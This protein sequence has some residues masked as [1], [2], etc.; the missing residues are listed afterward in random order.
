[1][2]MAKGTFLW[3]QHFCTCIDC[4][5]R[6]QKKDICS[7]C[8]FLS[9][10]LSRLLAY[11]NRERRN[12]R[13]QDWDDSADTD[14]DIK[15]HANAKDNDNN[16]TNTNH[17]NNNKMTSMLCKKYKRNNHSNENKKHELEELV[18]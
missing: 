12:E 18:S 6:D 13:N 15:M 4:K 17:Y 10:R 2:A 5:G 9:F 8:K 3:N 14:H 16:N 1:M 11:N 7:G